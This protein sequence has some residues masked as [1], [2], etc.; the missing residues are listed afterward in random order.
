MARYATFP[1][2]FDEALQISISRLKEWN[3]LN[4]GR[5]SS[6][7][8]TWSK[9]GEPVGS[10]SFSANLYD[11]E[12]Y[13]ELDYKYKDEPRN[14]KIK[15]IKKASNLGEGKGFQYYFECPRTK[16]L[17]KKLYSIGGYFYHRE[18]FKF[19]FYES[20]L[21]NQQYRELKKAFGEPFKL[22]HYYKRLHKKNAKTQY[23]GKETKWY[24]AIKK[25]IVKAEAFEYRKM[26]KFLFGK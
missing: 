5:L 18:A 6:G 24:S 23:N 22:E 26:E 13:I 2:L 1:T 20:Q 17:C 21:E 16:K 12:P 25:K 9:R 11:P 7:T 8:L 14:Y 10:I 19:C 4:E 3:Y 15:L